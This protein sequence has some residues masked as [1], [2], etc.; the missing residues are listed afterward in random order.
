MIYPDLQEPTSITHVVLIQ[1]AGA[2]FRLPM[3]DIS[4]LILRLTAGMA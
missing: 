4:W 1:K 2:L 3:R